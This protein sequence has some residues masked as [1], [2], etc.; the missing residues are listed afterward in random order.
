MTKKI[1]I[2][3][4]FFLSILTITSASA[5]GLTSVKDYS[6]FPLLDGGVESAKTIFKTM[7]D[8][9]LLK[10]TLTTDLDH[11]IEN[12]KKDDYQ[13][14]TLTIDSGDG[15]ELHNVKVKPRGKFRRSTCDFPPLKIKFK[16]E[17]LKEKGI[18]TSHKS[19]KLV[20]HCMDNPDAE[21]TIL[22]EYIAYKMYNQLT[23][24]SF[25]VQLVEVTYV[26]SAKDTLDNVK[27]GFII[28]NTNEMAERNEGTEVENLYNLTLDSINTKYSHLIPMFQYMISNMDWRPKMLQNVK[29]IDKENGDRIMVP[30]DFDFSGLVNA[31]YAIPNQDFKQSDVQ[32]RI[33]MNRVEDIKE[34]MPTIKY[35][36]AKKEDIMNTIKQ[37]DKLSKKNR[38]EMVRYVN[39]FYETLNDPSTRYGAFVK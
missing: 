34:L 11:L 32:E 29:F 5:Q 12:K 22:K 4:F 38:K 35:F 18:S 33:Y 7:N 23:D 10:V 27:Y 17:G 1:Q 26:N 6:G 21:Q 8:T 39:D 37:C 9:D 20:T 15:L 36:T 16:K 19:L 31:P 30:Y 13:E 28:E 3:A 25:K 24:A 2:F 14:A